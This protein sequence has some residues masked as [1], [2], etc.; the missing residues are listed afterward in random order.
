[1]IL[2]LKVYEGPEDL[3]ET[4][5]EC[6]FLFSEHGVLVPG[7]DAA[8]RLVCPTADGPFSGQQVTEIGWRVLGQLLSGQAEEAASG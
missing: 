4:H 5:A 2:T 1:M 7:A 8:G 6:G 3:A